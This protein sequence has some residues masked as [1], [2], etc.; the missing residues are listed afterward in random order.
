MS[1]DIELNDPVHHDTVRSLEIVWG[2]G[3][4]GGTFMG[5]GGSLFSSLT[6]AGIVIAAVSGYVGLATLPSA[7]RVAIEWREQEDLY[8]D[9]GER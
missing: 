2:G 8:E 3:L 6:I 7:E 9:G 1:L 4:V 5:L